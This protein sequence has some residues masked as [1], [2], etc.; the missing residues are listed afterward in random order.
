[1]TEA[2]ESQQKLSP[3]PNFFNLLKSQDRKRWELQKYPFKI[4]ECMRNENDREYMK[5][6]MYTQGA[7]IR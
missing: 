7:D 5:L 3:H 1:M 2:S 4:N 6:G